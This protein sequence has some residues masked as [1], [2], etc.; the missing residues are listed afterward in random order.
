MIANHTSM[1]QLFGH[2]VRQYDKLR[3]RNA[4]LDQYRKEPT[5]SENLDEFDSARWTRPLLFVSF[6]C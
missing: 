6:L 5:F 1:A 2:T 4:F 3:G